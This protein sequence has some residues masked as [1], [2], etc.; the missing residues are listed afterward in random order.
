MNQEKKPMPKEQKKKM[1]S[2][3]SLISPSNR[4]A[5]AIS[6]DDQDVKG[7]KKAMHNLN[8]NMSGQEQRLSIP[9]EGFLNELAANPALVIRNVFQVFHDMMKAY[10]GE[11]L[12]E[13]SDDP[14][15]IHYVSQKTV[16]ASL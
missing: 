6:E 10:V 2:V 7:I 8:Q 5:K 16:Y 9:F 12:D 15:S 13:Y 1:K 11:G 14:E 4:K 3:N